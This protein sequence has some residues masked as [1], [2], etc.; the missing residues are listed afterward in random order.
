MPKILPDGEMA[1]CI[2]SLN[3]AVTV[4]FSVVHAWAKNYVKFN[5]HEVKPEH[6]LL[7]HCKDHKK[8]RIFLLEPTGQSAVNIM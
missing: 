7:Y 3:I 2:N 5:R 6:V 8:P 4:V 1:E